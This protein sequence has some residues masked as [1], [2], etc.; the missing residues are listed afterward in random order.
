MLSTILFFIVAIVVQA[1]ALKLTLGLLGQ[2]SANNKFSTALGV[3]AM[4]KVAMVMT[5]FLPIVGWVLKPLIWLLIIMAVYNTG[6]LKTI[7]VAI[8]QFVIQKLLAWILAVI[9]FDQLPLV[10]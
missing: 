3:A 10:S 2:A 1:V 7:A 6:F 9:G 8:V 4:L 5:T